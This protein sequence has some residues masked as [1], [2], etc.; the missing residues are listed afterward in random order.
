MPTNDPKNYKDFGYDD[1]VERR[2]KTEIPAEKL[3]LD[4]DNYLALQ[5]IN[6]LDL[7]NLPDSSIPGVTIGSKII[8]D[9]AGAGGAG[10]ASDT[11]WVL[12]SLT[13]DPAT[14]DQ[15]NNQTN[16]FADDGNFT[17]A[18]LLG[19]STAT[20]TLWLHEFGIDT[21]GWATVEGIE[22]KLDCYWSCTATGVP[23]PSQ[24][25]LYLTPDLRA[26][27]TAGQYNI[28]DWPNGSSSV[29]TA[30]GPADT[31]GRTWALSELSDAAFGVKVFVKGPYPWVVGSGTITFYIDAAWVRI[32]YT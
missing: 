12:P 10:G 5:N 31:W 23:W 28:A 16:V 19:G 7:G 22:V 6:D 24:V 26:T 32:Y 9:E 17:S 8:N 4:P 29:I 13:F 3:D 25:S 18:S 14:I 21:T 15:W 2:V 27:V 30:G 20:A 11:D 1:F